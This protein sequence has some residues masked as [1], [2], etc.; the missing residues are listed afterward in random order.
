[1]WAAR[2]VV[3]KPVWQGAVS[4]GAVAVAQAIGPLVL[5]G[6]VKALDLA[7]PAWGVG[8][9][10]DVPDAVLR[11]HLA[12]R[13]V[14]GV[15]PGAVGHQPPGGDAVAGKPGKRALHE[16]GDGRGALVGQQ[17]AVGEPRVIV[18]EWK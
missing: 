3:R 18:D 1:V 17:L 10:D 7:V 14:V 9:R 13:A 6:L 5:H 2:V 15:G 16:G 4:G 12:R 11:E 8:G